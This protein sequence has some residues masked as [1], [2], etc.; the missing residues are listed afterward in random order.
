MKDPRLQNLARILVHYS[1][2][3]Q[4]G[5]RVG[6]TAYGS[7]PEA[8][9]LLTEIFREVLNAG[10][11]P[12][13]YFLPF[14]IEGIDSIF[15][16][17]ANQNQLEYV[18]P[19]YEIIAKEFDCD[20]YF[21]CQSN[22]RSLSNVDPTRIQSRRRAY[23][24]LEKIYFQRAAEG[25]LRWVYAL[26][27]TPGF[28]QDAEM[29]LEQY[30]D[31][32]YSATYADTDDPISSWQQVE[33]YQ[34]RLVDWFRG[35]QR[36]ELKGPH[37]DLSFS[38]E[39]RTFISCDGKANMPDG[40]IFTG[41]VEDTVNGWFESTFPAIH[42]GVDVGQVALRFE[43]GRVVHAQAEKHPDHLIQAIDTD[44][45]AHYLGEF[46]IGTNDRI[47]TFTK[48][49]LFDEKI[50][51]TIHVALGIGFPETGS[52]NESAIHWDFLCDMR[53]GGQIIVDDQLIYES[54]EFEI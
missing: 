24:E 35:K 46:G 34:K 12:H 20:I 16:S 9:P 8:Y 53:A 1:T 33:Q 48:N 30:E 4:P 6:I 21:K 27:P 28:A 5:E 38:I 26:Y 37:V 50:A 51:G 13:I 32:V 47:Q 19:F 18:D 14:L 44:E 22:T 41:P 45:G 52:K 49:M 23:T 10:G 2:H 15:Y 17:E 31:F 3:I 25:S 54:G 39:E 40:E 7:A 29:S 42:D 11:Y 43:A 36:V